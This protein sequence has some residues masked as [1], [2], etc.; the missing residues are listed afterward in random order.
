MNT[1]LV[2]RLLPFLIFTLIAGG[3]YLLCQTINNYNVLDFSLT[4]IIKTLG[5]LLVTSLVAFL[6]SMAP[7]VI[8]LLFLPKSWVN[9]KFDK[10]F[11][12][13]S[14]SLFVFSTYFE[15]TAA[16]IFWDEF[17]SAFNFIAVD[18]LVYTN[19]V[20]ANI[21]ESYPV[22]SI[23]GTLVVLTFVTV[24]FTKRWLFID[25]AA[26]RFFRRLFYTL[27]YGLV[28]VLAYH[29]IDMSNLEVN[30]NR[31]NNELSKNG[32]YSLFSAYLKNEI[33]YSDFYITHD[34]QTN[35]EILQNKFKG[36]NV[37]F[38]N[39]TDI[40]RHIST[41]RPEQKHNVIIVLMESMSSKFL[42]ENR[43][44]GLYKVTPNLDRLSQEGL[45][46]SNT[47][48]SGTRSVRGIEAVTLSVPPLPGQSIV[49]R[50][51]NE[52]LHSLGSIFAKKGYD[53]KWIYG[54]L[55]Y[56]DNMNYFLGNNGFQVID[57][58][59]WT[60]D[61][62]TFAN[63]W[64]ASDEDTFAK[65]IKEADKSYSSGKP[66]LTFLLTISNHRP[67]TYPDGKIDIKGGREGGVKYADY[68]I[69]EFITQAKTKP[70]FDNTL[71]V[72][73]ADHTAGAAGDE[74]IN[75]EDHHIPWIIY[76][77][78]LVKAQRIDTPVSQLDVLPTILGLLNFDYESHFYGQDAL[79]PNYES[80]FF[81]SNF[82]KVGYVKDGIDIILKPIKEHSF[83]PQEV[84]TKEQEELLNEAVAFYQTASDWK[85]NLKD[86]KE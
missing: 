15:L 38:K 54:G 77:P 34:P 50:P 76:A 80:R 75:L 70:W 25:I 84:S 57:R 65:V 9:Q 35:I 62:I 3:I 52:N 11:T 66:F 53:N 2:R 29:N 73:V 21:T 67:Y 36:N 27:V 31:F 37:A 71:F 8:Y 82:Q 19:E 83:H 33:S 42:T 44:P 28:C 48:A 64:G 74:E 68:A 85:Q 5:V 78:K 17:Q 69:G 14:Y 61:E 18:Y 1:Y 10:F 47:Y 22:W 59:T 12:I 4:A 43:Y 26:P 86:E 51:E 39:K 79:S 55:G 16:W 60:E 30:T 7:F 45:F 49:R 58:G 24:Y 13:F 6:F 72:F 63:A 56:F 81:V 40:T 20:I 23:I 41:A 46:F 32:R